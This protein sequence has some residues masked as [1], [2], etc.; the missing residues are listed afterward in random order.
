MF[1]K[2]E[3]IQFHMLKNV[4]P[5]QNEKVMDTVT[6]T[7]CSHFIGCPS[8]VLTV[9]VASPRSSRGL[10]IPVCSSVGLRLNSLNLQAG[11][12]GEEK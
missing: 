6:Y 11:S 10:Y 1:P 12:Q 3:D 7:A 8:E 9:V 2:N 4:N 5:N